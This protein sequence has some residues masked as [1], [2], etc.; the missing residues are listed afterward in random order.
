[1]MVCLG[2]FKGLNV[3]GILG[4]PRGMGKMKS[5][6]WTGPFHIGF[7]PHCLGI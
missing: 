4:T 3:A 2:E 7:L 5:E 6:G 1:M